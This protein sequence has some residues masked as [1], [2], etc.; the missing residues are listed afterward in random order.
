MRAWLLVLPSGQTC[1]GL[2]FKGL[3]L[4]LKGLRWSRIEGFRSFACMGVEVAALGL[5]VC[6][7]V[8]GP[9]AQK[10]RQGLQGE[11]LC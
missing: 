2:S 8:S 4:E 9:F 1:L 5:G 3:G 6:D 10:S 7:L 11:A